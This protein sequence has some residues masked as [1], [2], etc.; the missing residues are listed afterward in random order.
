MKNDLTYREVQPVEFPNL[1][2]LLITEAPEF[3]ETAIQVLDAD[4]EQFY[5]M[6]TN[7]GKVIA[8]EYQGRL[9]G[10]YW[11]DENGDTFHLHALVLRPEFQNRGIGSYV[12]NV[13]EDATGKHFKRIDVG[14]NASNRRA[15][16]FLERHGYR[17]VKETP[18]TNYVFMQKPLNES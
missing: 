11:I 18:D 16:A 12:M 3:V 1:F 14:F 4:E 8:I 15:R 5:E 9:A 7:E 17:V 2:K 13:V 6:F 10:Y